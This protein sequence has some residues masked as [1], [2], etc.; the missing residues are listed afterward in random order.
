ME[1]LSMVVKH[2][3]IFIFSLVAV[4]VAAAFGLFLAVGNY[5]A[6]SFAFYMLNYDQQPLNKDPFVGRVIGL[7]F[8]DVTLGHLYA[9]VL[10]AAVCIAFFVL[11]HKLSEIFQHL[12]LRREHL[13]TG[14]SQS[15]RTELERAFWQAGEALIIAIPAV[16]AG[17]FDVMLFRFRSIVGAMGIEDPSMAVQIA[18]WQMQLED[19]LSLFAWQLTQIGA[20]GYIGVTAVGCIALEYALRRTG[21]KWDMLARVIDYCMAP[22]LPED[23]ET[24]YT[25][26]AGV[27]EAHGPDPAV[28]GFANGYDADT[29]NT[30]AT[31]ATGEP[32][33]ENPAPED[34]TVDPGFQAQEGADR[35]FP[36]AAK[37]VG[38]EVI[39]SDPPERLTLDEALARPDRYFVDPDTMDVW[40]RKFYQ[41][42]NDNPARKAA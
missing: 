23:Q 31:C 30:A 17:W 3:V 9:L 24:Q 16:L 19:N 6:C 35:E 39:G 1:K 25:D 18:N 22:G 38:Q 36:S 37:P 7:F 33:W 42:M 12:R 41:T 2:I 14:D 4:C 5:Q 11:F 29:G 28:G 13:N 40:S 21:E 34:S 8:K 32:R 10:T 26:P 15:A 20:W 27:D